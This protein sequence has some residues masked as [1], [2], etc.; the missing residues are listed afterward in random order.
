MHRR[1]ARYDYEN[2]AVLDLDKI[3]LRK[4]AKAYKGACA[5]NMHLDWVRLE[6]WP[7]Y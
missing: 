1:W 2:D 6:M 3:R 7:A 5:K 4:Y